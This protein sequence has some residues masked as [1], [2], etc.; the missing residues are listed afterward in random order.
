[1]DSEEQG[2]VREIAQAA[3]S[4]ISQRPT[5]AT[6]VLMTFSFCGSIVACVWLLAPQLPNMITAMCGGQ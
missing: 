6:A 3:A 5:A 2:K 1:M 4:S